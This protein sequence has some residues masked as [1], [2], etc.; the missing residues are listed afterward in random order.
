MPAFSRNT[1]KACAMMLDP[2]TL[3]RLE[4]VAAEIRALAGEDERAFADTLEGETDAFEMLDRC[5][6]AV[7]EAKAMK[8]A[9]A[10]LAKTYRDRATRLAEKEEAARRMVLLLVQAI[11]PNGPIRR[12]AATV[13]LKRGEGVR[14]AVDDRKAIPPAFRKPG[15]PDAAAIEAR[16]KAGSAVPG[17]RLVPAEDTIILRSA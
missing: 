2:V 8:E 11:K 3:V 14:L 5:L 10:A 12:A 1:E 7:A 16:L 15:D 6:L 9:N 4:A 17:A 13:T